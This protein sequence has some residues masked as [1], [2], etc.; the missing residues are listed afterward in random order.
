[1][2]GSFDVYEYVDYLRSRWKFVAV[3]CGAAVVLSLGVSLALPKKYSAVARIVIEPP[4]GSEVRA[5]MTVSPVYLES[6]KTYLAFASSDSLFLKAAARFGLRDPQRPEPIS[7]LKRS[8]LKVELPRDTKIM[9]ITAT[10]GDPRKAQA[11]ASYL[12]DETVRLTTEVGVESDRELIADSEQQLAASHARLDAVQSEWARLVAAEPT[13]DLAARISAAQELS[14]SLAEQ[15]ASS[16]VFLAESEDREKALATADRPGEFEE[17]RKELRAARVRA[18][19]LGK[20][21]QEIERRNAARQSLLDRR[22]ADREKVQA[23]LKAAEGACQ[24]LENRLTEVR[25]GVGYRNER[26]HVID[27]G[28][29]P[30]RPSS[31]NIPLNVLVALLAAVVLSFLLLTLR[32]SYAVGREEPRPVP[33]RMVHDR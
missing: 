12:A 18:E 14:A 32:F 13:D 5:S 2:P 11:L 27:Q 26:L 1:M 21:I 17:T 8:I 19:G 31:P 25:A 24:S 33:M 29:V 9:E 4:A 23:E 22:M 20:Q 6:L 7:A 15:L 28:I 16:E 3:A 30:E 10:L